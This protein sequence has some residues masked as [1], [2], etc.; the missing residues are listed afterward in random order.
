MAPGQGFI[1]AASDGRA[2]G[3][4]RMA[5]IYASPCSDVTACC[6]AGQSYHRCSYSARE[7]RK[8]ASG[9]DEPSVV[10]LTVVHAVSHAPSRRPR[11]PL[12]WTGFGSGAPDENV[13]CAGWKKRF[14]ARLGEILR[15]RP[16]MVFGR[17]LG[18][19]SGDALNEYM[20]VHA[21]E[22]TLPLAIEVLLCTSFNA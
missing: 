7:A 1:G 5:R 8:R 4:A 17:P 10:P 16:Q 19:A 2:C 22:S 21:T 9:D 15:R 14:G 18:G 3:R 20:S 11:S 6:A 13:R 12:P